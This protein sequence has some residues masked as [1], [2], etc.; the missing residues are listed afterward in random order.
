MN[1]APGIVQTH[2][3]KSGPFDKLRAGYGVPGFVVDLAE[4]EEVDGHA[5][6]EEREDDGEGDGRAGG[7]AGLPGSGG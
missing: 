6:A 7:L 3:R 1:G 4:A 2:V 5:C